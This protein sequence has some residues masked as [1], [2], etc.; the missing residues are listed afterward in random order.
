MS[1]SKCRITKEKDLI[2]VCNLGSHSLCG[3]FPESPEENLETG[4]LELG[5]SPSSGLLQLTEDRDITSM[6]GDNYGY[7]SGLNLSM[8]KHLKDKVG[9]LSSLIELNEEKCVL[10]I[11]SNDGTLL[12][13]YS[14]NVF[15]IWIITNKKCSYYW[16]KSCKCISYRR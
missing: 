14:K 16:R 6:Y 15:K 7:R 3:Y 11:G 12:S 2:S 8:V 9:Y 13:F 4:S 5:W 10:D 1:Q